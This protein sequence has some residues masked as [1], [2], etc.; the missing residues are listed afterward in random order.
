MEYTFWWSPSFDVGGDAFCVLELKW[1][2]NKRVSKLVCVLNDIRFRD[3][4]IMFVIQ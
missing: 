2:E 3:V 4:L 1:T